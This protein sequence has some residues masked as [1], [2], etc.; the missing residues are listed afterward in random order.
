M[1][2]WLFCMKSKV[3]YFGKQGVE[4]QTEIN[5]LQAHHGI[6]FSFHYVVLLIQYNIM[7]NVFDIED[8]MPHV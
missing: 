8:K 7:L 5:Y 3:K 6:H 4:E 2:W 1:S